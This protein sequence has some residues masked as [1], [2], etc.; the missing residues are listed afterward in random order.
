MEW[1][2]SKPISSVNPS[3]QI[4]TNKVRTCIGTIEPDSISF[5]FR[6]STSSPSLDS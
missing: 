3:R 1:S 2:Y 6:D 4:T 5:I